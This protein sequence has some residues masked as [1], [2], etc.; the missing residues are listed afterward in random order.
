[1]ITVKRDHKSNNNFIITKTDNE[2]YH[3]QLNLTKDE[4]R[5]LK[6]E[7]LFIFSENELIDNELLNKL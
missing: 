3:S 6:N 4:L 1:M 5:V 2:G 7:I